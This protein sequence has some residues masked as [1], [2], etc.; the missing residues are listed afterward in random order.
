MA[1]FYKKP[2]KSLNCLETNLLKFFHGHMVLRFSKIGYG[3]K[4]YQTRIL[5]SERLLLEAPLK[6]GRTTFKSIL[7]CWA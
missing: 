7:Y 4:Q 2:E 5:L 3:V 6:K 1:N